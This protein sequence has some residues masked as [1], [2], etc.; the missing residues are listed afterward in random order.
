MR[1]RVTP[2]YSRLP[3]PLSPCIYCSTF[4][5][6]LWLNMQVAVSLEVER[7]EEELGIAAVS[8]TPSATTQVSTFLSWNE[9]KKKKKSQ[10]GLNA[11][12]KPRW[13][14]GYRRRCSLHLFLQLKY[15][16]QERCLLTS[17]GPAPSEGLLVMTTPPFPSLPQRRW[18]GV[19]LGSSALPSVDCAD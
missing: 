14:K 4:I 12:R 7:W 2:I 16:L 11:E 13:G 5:H 10:R 6:F 9:R 8:L 19:V 18:R 15:P 3:R 17:C 1:V